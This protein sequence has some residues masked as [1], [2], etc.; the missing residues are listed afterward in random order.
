M[1]TIG[2]L[3]TALSA[4]SIGIAS[5]IGLLVGSVAY[6]EGLPRLPSMAISLSVESM[7]TR[8]A[9][10]SSPVTPMWIISFRG[11]AHIA[12]PLVMI[13]GGDE[14]ANFSGTP[15]GRDGWAQYF[16][17]LGYAVYMVDQVGRG[18]SPYVES[19]YGKA[20]STRRNS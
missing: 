7:S 6:A 4:A 9:A 3:R 13:A 1:G 14:R 8:P 11:S 2:R 18:R 16:V 20:A 15:D 19:V 12:Y 10:R 5:L 17:N